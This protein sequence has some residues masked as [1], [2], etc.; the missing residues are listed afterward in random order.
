[1]N[2][3][4]VTCHFLGEDWEEEVLAESGDEAENDVF[5]RLDNHEKEFLIAINWKPA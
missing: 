5:E 3:Y 2:R 1:M 4:I